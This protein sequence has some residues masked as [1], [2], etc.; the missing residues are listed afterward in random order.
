M[1]ETRAPLLLLASGL[2]VLGASPAW[3]GHVTEVTSAFDEGNPYDF[4]VSVGYSRRLKRGAIKREGAGKGGYQDRVHIFKDLRYSHV[5]HQLSVRAEAAIFRDLQLHVEF[6]IVLSDTRAIDFALD[7]GDECIYPGSSLPPTCVNKRNSSLVNDGFL[8]ASMVQQMANTQVQVAGTGGGALAPGGGWSGPAFLDLPRRSGLDQFYLGLTWAPV[9][10]ARDDTKPT[11]ILGFEARIAVGAPMEYNLYFD[12][13]KPESALNPK[14]NSSVGRGIHQLH[15]FTSL[16]RRYRYIDPWITFFYMYPIAASD[17]LFEKTRFEASG[18]ERSN[19]Q[20]RGGA[21]AG[22]E[23]IAWEEPEK[24][25]KFSVELRARLEGVFEGRG[26]SPVWELFAN[27][28]I[29][30]GPC[31]SAPGST[32]SVRYNNGTYCTSVTT[33][34]PTP[35]PGEVILYPGITSIEN[36]A[37]FYATLAFNLDFTKY[38]RARAGLSLGHVQQHFITFGDA[39]RD[40]GGNKG[41][42]YESEEEVNPMYRPLIDQVGRRFRLGETTILDVFVELVGQF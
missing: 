40:I 29:L 22:M 9:N 31:R 37:E 1:R 33:A 39:G 3:A 35:D 41:I 4:N 23:I 27:N 14:T 17:S 20:Q 15:F 24:R 6:P 12:P 2:L 26:Y 8:P 16:A 19:P 30:S 7:G 13:S 21:E 25:N 36:H 18:Q 5:R 32:Q 10:Q 28:P 11:W 34:K 42:D 38:F